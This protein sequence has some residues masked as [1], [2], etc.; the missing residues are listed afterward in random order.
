MRGKTITIYMPDGNPRSMKVCDIKTS[1]VKAIYIPRNKISELSKHEVINKHLNDPCVYLLFGETDLGKT[2]TYIGEA[3]ELLK[4]LKR[5]DYQKD[6]WN[7]V[8]C[9]V[10]AKKNHLNKAH[11]KFLESHAYNKAREVNRVRLHNLNIPKKSRLTQSEKD[12][13]LDFFDDMRI[14]TSA[15]GYPIFEERKDMEYIYCKSKNADAKGVYDEE[16]LTVIKGSKCNLK[17]A[18]SAKDTLT[19]KRNKLVESGILEKTE[20][21][22]VFKEDYT[23]NSPSAA[24]NIV[25]ARNA[26]GWTVWKFEDGKTLDQKIRKKD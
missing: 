5:Q 21:T 6:F 24:A 23:F 20:D 16:G 22:Y 7:I 11:I 9:F 4:R 26:N 1:T 2:E 10:S 15:L 12:Y 17:P 19:S 3:E 14:L 8:L 25:L 13:A 18:P